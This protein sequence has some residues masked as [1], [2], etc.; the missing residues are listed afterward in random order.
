MRS[1]PCWPPTAVS[2]ANPSRLRRMRRVSRMATSSSTTRMR[3]CVKSRASCGMSERRPPPRPP[4]GT[5]RRWRR[6]RRRG[7]SPR[8]RRP[9][10]PRRRAARRQPQPG[11]AG[12]QREEGVEDVLRVPPPPRRGRCRRRGCARCGAAPRRGA[13]MSVLHGVHLHPHAAPPDHW[14]ALSTRLKTARCSRS[15]SPL[16]AEPRV[17]GARDSRSP[18]PRRRGARGRAPPRGAPAPPAD[19]SGRGRSGR[20]RSR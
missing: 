4:A 1:T 20:G 10:G 12:A 19:R 15:S 11:A 18:P 6:R 16:H 3:V 2:T 5:G 9:R 17:V 8:R 14:A 7:R 13:R